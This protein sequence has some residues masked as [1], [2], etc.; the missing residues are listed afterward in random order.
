MTDTSRIPV[1]VG[2]GDLKGDPAD[3]RE[4]LDLIHDAAVLAL[5]DTGHRALASQLDAVH[6]V[7]TVS[8]SYENLPE[9]LAARLG[10]APAT[11]STSPIGGHW[12]AALLDRIGAD[13]AAGR[14]SVALLVGG[15]CSATTAALRK[16][17]T[18]LDSAG[19]T[20]APGG[21]PG[22]NPS[23][24]GSPQMQRTGLMVP[25]RV[26]P[27]FENSFSA[28]EGHDAAES[29]A[30]SARMYAEF[31]KLAAAH[32][33]SWTSTVHT[34][35]EISTVGPGNRMIGEPYPLML[36]AM[37]FVDQAA[38]VVVCSLDKAREAGIDEDRFVYLWGGAGASDPLDV[39]S[40]SN[41][42]SSSALSDVVRR[43]L[44][45]AGVSSDSLDIVD[46]YSCFPV[47]P[48]LLIR[49]LNLPDTT[50]P[51]VTGGHSFFGGP[52]NSYT[53]HSVAEVTRRLRAGADLALVH[54]N[55]GFLTCQHTL[56]LSSSA[57]SD[58]YVGDP[59]TRALSSSAPDQVLDY[60]GSA[61]IVTATVEYG[62]GGEPETGFVVA[63]TPDGRRLAGHTGPA[64]AAALAQLHGDNPPAIGRTVRVHDANGLLTLEF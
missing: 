19:W 15:E 48:K 36:N 46:A 22:F 54:G 63:T 51:S 30:W 9:L 32:P 64:E 57:H 33:A 27:L 14:S 37:P 26:Y 34:A 40:R 53:L 2:I 43:T 50:I 21:P 52:L 18:D 56:L 25:T 23:D 5:D 60:S 42:H 44:D 45:G 8:W 20:H 59:E 49:E 16:A 58:G 12:P 28:S 29:P 38:A 4:P 31:S 55:G 11:T 17:G 41:F 10:A 62:R 35:E 3:V 47:V 6:A 39:L 24:L 1:I 61:D 13:I 7:K